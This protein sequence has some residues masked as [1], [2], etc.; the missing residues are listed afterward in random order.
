LPRAP[1]PAPAPAAVVAEP[2]PAP[3]TPPADGWS[4]L[5]VIGAWACRF[6]LIEAAEALCV[7]DPRGAA[8]ALAA[9]ALDA[10]ESEGE[11]ALSA[12]GPEGT[13][14]LGPAADRL[15]AERDRWRAVGLDLQ[16]FGPGVLRLA[17]RPK[18]LA[19][20]AP[21]ALLA[22]AAA[23][24]GDG[25]GVPAAKAALAAAAGAAAPTALSAYECRELLRALDRAGLRPIDPCP[26]ATFLPLDS[27][28]R[29]AGRP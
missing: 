18:A 26:F 15:L 20:L 9:R 22:A 17:E 16:P 27:F 10:L 12:V 21:A 1:V 24:A 5:R 13:V 7:L 8:A 14:E 6:V 2:A 29:R 11:D 19:R 4:G 28:S 25:G 23:R 3:F